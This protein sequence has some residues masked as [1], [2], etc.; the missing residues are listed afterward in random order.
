M[1]TGPMQLPATWDL[2]AEGYAVEVPVQFGPFLEE[3]ARIAGITKDSRVLDIA[4][5]PGSLAFVVAPRVASV[6]ATDFSP[7]MIDELRA[8]AA[9]DGIAN[10]EA[11]VMDAQDLAL[12]DASFDA[13][14]C[15]FGF[16]FFPD[17]ARAFA[18]M[19][20]VLRPGGRAVV[21][22]WGPIDKRP[23]TKIGFE[24]IAEVM[25]DL[26][27]MAKGDMQ[28]VDDCLREVRDAGFRDVTAHAFT[29]STHIAS[30]ERYLEIV[31]RSGAPIAML[32]KKIGEEGWRG[33]RAKV[34]DAVRRRLPDAPVDLTAEAIFTVGT[35]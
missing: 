20:R 18:E 3:A 11:T 10:I 14:F 16:M 33:L 35:R 12:P 24:A 27:R 19:K 1:S 6:V 22:T 34:L 13:A 25:P 15:L 32:K 5:G 30:A 29:A 2:V 23:I 8:R 31:E 9:R 28:S 26:P 4:T 17:R 7:G 21:A